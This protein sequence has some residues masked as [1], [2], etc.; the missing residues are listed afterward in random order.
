MKPS[1]RGRAVVGKRKLIGFGL[2]V[3]VGA[4]VCLGWRAGPGLL[5]WALDDTE[6]SPGYTEAN[7]D[8]VRE[9]MTEGEVVR[10]LGRPLDSWKQDPGVVR[11]YGPPGSSVDEGGGLHVPGS[12]WSKSAVIDFDPSGRTARP[13][14]PFAG[15]SPDEV[16]AALGEPIRE[17]VRRAVVLWRYTRSDGHHHRRWVGFDAAGMVAEKRAYFYWD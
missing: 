5:V 7:F 14:G 1:E 16:R 11:W 6:Y 2:G 3:G 17:E 13:G 10:L 15:A 9:G 4:L 8:A 12:D